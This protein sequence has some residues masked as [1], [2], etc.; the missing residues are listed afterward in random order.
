MSSLNKFNSSL[1]D[2]VSDHKKF[3]IVKKDI[4]NL[5]TYIEITK[6]N[7]KLIIRGFQTHLLRD[8]FVSNVLKN[9]LEFFLNYDVN[10]EPDTPEKIK[11]LIK[12]IQIILNDAQSSGNLKNTE[13]I[14]HW[15][16]VLCF[17]AY[18]ELGID[19]TEKFKNLMMLK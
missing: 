13:K 18:M 3:D 15:L 1:R 10:K 17:H 12:R 8:S 2:F 16:Q 9:N 4:E 5:E 7:S 6:V 14:F 19:A 11:E